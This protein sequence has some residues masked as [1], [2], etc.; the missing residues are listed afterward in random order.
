[1]GRKK[2]AKPSAENLL[3]IVSKM[4]VPASILADF[5]IYDAKENSV[6]W[7]IELREEMGR[8]LMK[9]KYGYELV[10]EYKD[11]FTLENERNQE[12]I[13]ACIETRST[14]SDTDP[15]Y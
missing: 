8:E 6:Q 4:L 9:P 10:L 7:T 1:M 5:D 11:I 3:E 15:G 12:I 13:W 14:K 2:I